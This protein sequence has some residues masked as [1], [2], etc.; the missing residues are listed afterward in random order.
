MD[1]V[2]SNN[3]TIVNGLQSMFNE[4]L[5]AILISISEKY[6]IDQQELF[7]CYLNSNFESKDNVKPTKKYKKHPVKSKDDICIAKKSDGLQCTRKKKDDTQYCGKH[8][9]N[10]RYGTIEL[11]DNNIDDCDKYIMTWTEQIDGINYL[12][13]SNNIVYSSNIDNPEILGKKSKEGKLILL[14]DLK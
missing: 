9:S 10:Q 4:K 11:D 3:N 13:D 7:D 6:D 12:I 2:I 14:S 5:T 1:S 8:S